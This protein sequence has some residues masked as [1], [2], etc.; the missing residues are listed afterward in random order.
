MWVQDAADME[1][2][3]YRFLFRVDKLIEGRKKSIFLK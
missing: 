1:R 2:Y 3:C